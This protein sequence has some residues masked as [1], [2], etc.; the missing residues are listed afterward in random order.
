MSVSKFTY[1]SD[2]LKISLEPNKTKQPVIEV[3]NDFKRE[4]KVL[5]VCDDDGKDSFDKLLSTLWT[6]A[7][8]KGLFRYQLKELPF[9]VLDGKY[10]FVLQVK[11]LLLFYY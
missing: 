11:K 4:A 3:S 1:S 9:K 5:D 8:T 7:Q 10:R 6:S 2:L